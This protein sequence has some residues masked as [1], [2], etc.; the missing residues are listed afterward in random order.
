MRKLTLLLFLSL[1]A[2]TFSGIA[3]ADIND[4]LL[5]YYPL[6]AN[7]NDASGNRNHGLENGGVSYVTGVIGQAASFDGID[8][9]IESRLEAVCQHFWRVF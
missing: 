9:F 6:D 3:F 5:A 8:D 1:L 4:G 7:A 2:F